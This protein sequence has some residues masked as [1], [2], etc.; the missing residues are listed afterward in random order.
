[1]SVFLRSKKNNVLTLKR[2]TKTKKTVR[3]VCD[4]PIALGAHRIV[5]EPYSIVK[6]MYRIIQSELEPYEKHVNNLEVFIRILF[7][8]T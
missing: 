5:R 2:I 3:E 1:M 4:F 8:G 6:E 7:P